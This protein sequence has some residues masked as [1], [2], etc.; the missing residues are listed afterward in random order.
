[1]HPNDRRELEKKF[2][3]ADQ[4]EE[5][6]LQKE[7]ETEEKCDLIVLPIFNDYEQVLK[8]QN[9]TVVRENK[10][11]LTVTRGKRVFHIICNVFVDHIEFQY[12]FEGAGVMACP[13]FT[14]ERIT[15]EDITKVF[16]KFTD[17]M[18]EWS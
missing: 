8:K 6:S 5:K 16:E 11:H 10:F 2:D 13:S 9:L 14:T 7:T 17:Y 3:E 15:S 1:M 18:L 12:E 4:K